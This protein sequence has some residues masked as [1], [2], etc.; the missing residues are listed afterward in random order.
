[1]EWQ[2][3]NGYVW[4]QPQTRLDSQGGS[5]LKE[6][7]LQIPLEPYKIWVMNLATV[8]FMDSSGLGAVVT[9]VK[10]ARSKGC[11]L[12]MCQPS[13]TARLI[14]EITQLDRVFEIIENI[15]EI[16]SSTQELLSA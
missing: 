14:F 2:E 11:R 1:M 15:E 6:Q 12:V 3:C 10:F 7:L 8:D 16:F 5:V 9:A 4:L 13:A